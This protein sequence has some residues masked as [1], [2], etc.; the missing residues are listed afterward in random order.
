MT[1][2]GAEHWANLKVL[3]AYDK[4]GARYPWLTNSSWCGIVP[5]SQ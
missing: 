1:F 5:V 4:L 3:Y 2:D